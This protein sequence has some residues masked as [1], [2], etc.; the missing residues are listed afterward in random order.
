MAGLKALVALAFFGSVGMT[1]L[2]I[3]CATQTNWVPFSVIV[4]YL[5][6]P[7]PLLISRRYNIAG[8]GGPSNACQEMAIFITVGIFISA[9]ALPIVLARHPTPSS[10]IT[11]SACAYT[12]AANVVV[13]LTIAGFFMTFGSEEMDY[14]MW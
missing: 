11:G 9:F 6:S 14:S 13:F 10:I 1:L 7:I 4:F 2:V 8:M 12:M 5:L 3:G